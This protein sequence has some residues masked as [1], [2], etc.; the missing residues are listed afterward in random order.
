LCRRT[1]CLEIRMRIEKRQWESQARM[2]QNSIFD[3][4]NGKIYTNFKP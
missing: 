3:Q 2:K 1:I 4:E